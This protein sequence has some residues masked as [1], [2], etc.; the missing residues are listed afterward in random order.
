[1]HFMLAIS[2]GGEGDGRDGSAVGNFRRS[3][4]NRKWRSMDSVRHEES[5]TATRSPSPAPSSGIET[6]SMKDSPMPLD[7]VAADSSSLG[8]NLLSA[9][10]NG[11]FSLD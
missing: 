2:A 9:A 3:A 8:N 4:I 11:S 10:K 5:P 6:S 7:F 1:M